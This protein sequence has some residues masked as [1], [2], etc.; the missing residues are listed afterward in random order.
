MKTFRLDAGY[1]TLL[2]MD[3]QS[4]QHISYER[5][6]KYDQLVSTTRPHCERLCQVV[7]EENVSGMETFSSK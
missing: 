2:I 7:H 1:P 5:P 4:Q 6:C 3:A